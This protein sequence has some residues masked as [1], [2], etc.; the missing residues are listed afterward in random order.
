MG[1]AENHIGPGESAMAEPQDMREANQTYEGFLGLAKYGT[2]AVLAVAA[3]V[4]V[5]IS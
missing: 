4:V 2:I 3:L 1:A 5:L